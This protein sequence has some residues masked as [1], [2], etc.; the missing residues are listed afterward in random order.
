MK[1]R[2]VE[3]P[4]PA[5]VEKVVS[6]TLGRTK[7]ELSKLPPTGDGQKKVYELVGPIRSLGK[8]AVP[9]LLRRL[10]NQ[11]ECILAIWAL[12][13]LAKRHRKQFQSC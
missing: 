3:P 2:P 12:E 11:K 6:E 10:Q 1:A 4:D 13:P 9:P 7:E 5:Q 8:N